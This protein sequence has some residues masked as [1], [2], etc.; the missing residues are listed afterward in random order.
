MSAREGDICILGSRQGGQLDQLDHRAVLADVQEGDLAL[1]LPLVSGL[2]RGDGEG[3]LLIVQSQAAPTEQ[4]ALGL[5]H[6]G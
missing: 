6:G 4:L 5:E 1:V 2:H 3:G